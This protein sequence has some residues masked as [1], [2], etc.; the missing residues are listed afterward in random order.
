LKRLAVFP[1]FGLYFSLLP[2]LIKLNI[3]YINSEIYGA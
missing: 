2:I 1:R 3:R